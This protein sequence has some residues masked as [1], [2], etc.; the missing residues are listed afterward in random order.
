MRSVHEQ[1]DSFDTGSEREMLALTEIE[2]NPEI[3]QRQLSK[4]IG[5]A[6]G[7]TN[8]LV[9]N[10][11]QKGLI[12]AS[13]A[14]WKRWI[15]NLTPKG[16]THKI[17]LTHRYI[18]RTVSSYN[19]IKDSIRNDISLASLNLESRVA[20]IGTEDFSELVYLAVKNYGIEDIDAFAFHPHHGQRFLGM[21]VKEATNSN[22]KHF[23]TVF[24][25]YMGSIDD[26][27]SLPKS[28]SAKVIVFTLDGKPKEKS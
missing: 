16:I 24:L 8:V 27:E 14:G 22:L 18:T 17:T 21:A 28:L 12:K 10:L 7:L 5:I 23:D 4:N 25:A 19:V 26:I 20:I 15:Y 9:K 3:T 13:Q 11:A 6:L 2:S 1:N